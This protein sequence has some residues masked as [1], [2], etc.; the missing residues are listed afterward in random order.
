MQLRLFDAEQDPVGQ[1]YEEHSYDP[2][3]GETFEGGENLK[4]LEAAKE[5]WRV[6]IRMYDSSSILHT[7]R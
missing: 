6:T 1:G 2:V 5:E 4:E 3:I 7:Y